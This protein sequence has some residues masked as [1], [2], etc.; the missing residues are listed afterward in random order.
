MGARL[1]CTSKTDRKMEIWLAPSP[2]GLPAG[3]GPTTMTLPSAGET[4]R[5]G[6]PGTRRSGSRK[7]KA[8]KRPSATSRPP[9]TCQR[10]YTRA[11]PRTSGTRMSGQPSRATDMF[12]WVPFGPGAHR[13]ET[14]VGGGPRR[15]PPA[16]GAG[17]VSRAL[18]RPGSGVSHP[19]PRLSGDGFHTVLHLQLLLL[20]SRFL[21]LL[22][23]AQHHLL[24]E[25]LKAT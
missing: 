2:S 1:M 14:R 18:R 15:R 13:P 20:Q 3:A 8:T 7:K 11:S 10:R 12:G 5:P 16:R 21:D 6:P 17:L 19:F 25:G 23:V 22:L 4:T 24:R 9:V